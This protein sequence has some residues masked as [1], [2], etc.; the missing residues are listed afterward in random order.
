VALHAYRARKKPRR[1]TRTGHTSPAGTR[2]Y[3]SPTCGSK[4]WKVSRL[5]GLPARSGC[6]VSLVPATGLSLRSPRVG[7]D[8][9]PGRGRLLMPASPAQSFLGGAGFAGAVLLVPAGENILPAR[10]GR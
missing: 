3:W 9:F 10:A 7:R 1:I 4:L 6:A 5:A 2:V 8:L